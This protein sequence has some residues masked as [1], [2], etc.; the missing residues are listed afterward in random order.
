MDTSSILIVWAALK[1]IQACHSVVESGS[2][3]T[4]SISMDVEYQLPEG[5]CAVFEDLETGEVAA[6]GGDPLVVELEAQTIY[7]GRF[8]INFMTAPIFEATASHCEGGILT[9]QW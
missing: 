1:T 6:L 2:Q 9:F 3:G 4:V 5:I 7:T 8:V